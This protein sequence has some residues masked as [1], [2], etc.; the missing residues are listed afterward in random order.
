[1]VKDP[2]DGMKIGTLVAWEF[3]LEF[4]GDTIKRKH[5]SWEDPTSEY[6]IPGENSSMM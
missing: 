3:G 6:T 4:N 1:M 2:Q 5:T